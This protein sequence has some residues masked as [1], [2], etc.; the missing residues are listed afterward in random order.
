MTFSRFI[1]TGT[2]RKTDN[3]TLCAAGFSA[4][5]QFSDP[6]FNLSLFS[7]IKY[8]LK[9][10]FKEKLTFVKK[11]LIIIPRLNKCTSPLKTEQFT[12]FFGGLFLC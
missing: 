5:A 2:D 10:S 8:F 1:I 9:S 11:Q 12:G 6:D 4:T 3:F 7:K